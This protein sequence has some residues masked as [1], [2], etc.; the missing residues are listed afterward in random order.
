MPMLLA[1][2]MHSIPL[3][4]FVLDRSVNIGWIAVQ[5]ETKGE[6]GEPSCQTH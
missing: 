2:P 3:Q 1:K 4:H 5:V 6:C